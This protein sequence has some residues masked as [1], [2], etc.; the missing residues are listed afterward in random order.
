M[1][2]LEILTEQI[3]DL[4]GRLSYLTIGNIA[5]GFFTFI[6]LYVSCQSF[7]YLYLSPLRH[8]PGPKLWAISRIPW[9]YVNMKGRIAW[10]VRDLHDRYGPVVRIAP[11][12]LSYTSGAT[13]KKIYGQRLPEFPKVLDGR[14]IAPASIGGRRTLA[15]EEHDRHARLRRAINPAFS[16]RALREQEYYFQKYIKIFIKQIRRISHDGP[17][18]MSLWYNL[19]SFDILSDLAFGA[20]A[21][22]LENADQPWI[23]VIGAR[24]K[25]FPWIQLAVQYGLFDFLIWI[26]PRRVTESRNKHLAMTSEK[27]KRR[28]Q[29]NSTNKDFFSY[30]LANNH[31]ERLTDIELTMLA[32][33]FIV[34]G[35]GT[36]AGGLAGI[37][38]LLLRNP[39]ALEKLKAEIR[40]AFTKEEEI[41]MVSVQNCKYLRAC[42][43]EGMRLYPPTPGTLPRWVPGKGEFIEGRWV[44]GGYAVG[45]NQLAAGHSEANFHRASEFLPERW[46]DI[47]SDSEF[48]SDDRTASQPFSLGS[49]NCVGKSMANAEMALA[50]A[51]LLWNFE[52]E[53][54]DPMENWWFKQGTFV[55]WEKLPLLVNLYPRHAIVNSVGIEIYIRT[56]I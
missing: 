48:A 24:T 55:V 53:L 29:S 35:S 7:Y 45:V 18:D 16:E 10:K 23:R 8:Y 41:T 39:E 12:E 2:K 34:A 21:G 37:T 9:N 44:P 33:T 17:V 40:T 3:K 6:A 15:T 27:V 31:E 20:P 28:I 54:H 13:W 47:G 51:M 56:E 14:G 22:C 43:S 26:S 32:S 25:S 1:I 11:D 49:R 4:L 38:Y 50:F 36:A 46:L 5:I 42:I 30:I 19:L 52:A